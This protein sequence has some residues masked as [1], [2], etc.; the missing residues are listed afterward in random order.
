[1]PVDL[2]DAEVTVGAVAEGDPAGG[3]RHFLHHQTVLHEAETRAAELR[4]SGDPQQ[5]HLAQLSP[6]LLPVWTNLF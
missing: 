5:T 6:E 4:V 1:M 2:I 3:P